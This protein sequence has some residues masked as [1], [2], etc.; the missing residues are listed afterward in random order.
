MNTTKFIE[1]VAAVAVADWKSRRIMLPSVVIA[2]AALES[3]WGGSELALKAN[4]LFGI[5]KNGWT[6]ATYIKSATEQRSDGSYYTVDNTEWRAYSSW[7]ES[8]LDHNDYIATRKKSDGSLRYEYIIGNTDCKDVCQLL[9]DCGYATSLTYPDKLMNLISKYELT[10]Y[11]CYVEDKKMF[12]IA[13][14]AGHGLY[15]GGKRCS[16]SLDSK[17]TR[18][19]WLNDRIADRLEALLGNYDCEVLRVDD[20]TGLT[21]V[22]L[23]NR[24]DKANAWG[25]DVYISI[26]HNA[27]ANGSTSGGTVVFYYPT[28]KCK[29]IAT[30]M[31]NSIVAK[32]G[33]VGNRSAK[34]SG[35]IGYHVLRKTKMVALLLENGFMD[36]KVDVPIILSAE[37]AENTAQGLLNFLVSE[38]KLNKLGSGVV[39]SDSVD[40]SFKVKVKVGSL[41]Y[42]AGAGTAYEIKGTITDKGIYTIVKTAKSSN[43]STWGL[44]KSRV[45]WINISNSYVTRV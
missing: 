45:G 43:G 40:T 36:S 27:G 22:P 12:K 38:Y 20:T 29:E 21:D 39:E 35:N 41:N 44:L 8:I 28:G 16:A 1:T 3:G 26:H 33:L 42:R 2:Q 25:A 4:A 6:G 24:T 37:H 23:K 10:K 15:T 31:Y 18:E 13:I 9:K 11:D 17:Q 30:R 19:W 5:K 34:I 7:T 14:D 32:T